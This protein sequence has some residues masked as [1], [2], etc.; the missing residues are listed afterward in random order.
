METRN[1]FKLVYVFGIIILLTQCHATQ[2]LH[3]S[4]ENYKGTL[5][6]D[7]VYYNK[8]NQM[9]MFL[10][11]NGV[12]FVGGIAS[13]SWEPG[14]KG[15][16]EFYSDTSNYKNSYNLPYRWG[17]YK[18]INDEV[19]FSGWLS[20]Y[21]LGGYATYTYNGKILNDTTLVLNRP[22]IYSVLEPPRKINIDTFYFYPC[23][24]KPDSTNKWIK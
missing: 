23:K 15:I 6:L 20:Y 3:F 18:V 1:I 4:R 21:E 16:E 11:A 9:F 5:R 19:I 17:I 12:R 13:D 14:V 24:Y 8:P 22:E 2:K 10:Y 7:G